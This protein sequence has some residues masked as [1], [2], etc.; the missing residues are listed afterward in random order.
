MGY[1]VMALQLTY[2]LVCA[3]H[4]FPPRHMSVSI[5]RRVNVFA[6]LSDRQAEFHAPPVSR[7]QIAPL[8][9]LADAVHPESNPRTRDATGTPQAPSTSK[10]HAARAAE[11]AALMH[12]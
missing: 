3:K 1:I 7:Y 4:R 11:P 10:L 2:W 12:T 5:V 8:P 9:A 6:E